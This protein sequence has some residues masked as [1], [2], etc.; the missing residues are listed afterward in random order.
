[1]AAR[2]NTREAR[3]HKAF[4]EGVMAG[5]PDMPV[6]IAC[7][8]PLPGD[9]PP[10]AAEIARRISRMGDLSSDAPK[11]RSTPPASLNSDTTSADSVRKRAL[12]KAVSTEGY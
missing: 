5:C 7:N 6:D 2:G 11:P 12:D 1:M 10:D 3:R 9:A 8:P 4:S